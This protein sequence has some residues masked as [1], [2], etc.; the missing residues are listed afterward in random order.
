MDNANKARILM[1]ILS[2]NHNVE[3]VMNDTF[4]INHEMY[5]YSKNTQDN[6]KN[7]N[8]I[9]VTG[10]IVVHTTQPTTKKWTDLVSKE[11]DT[12]EHTEIFNAKHI[13]HN[14][15]GEWYSRKP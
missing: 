9:I 15:V 8:G 7:P 5:Q 3:L 4:L 2:R 14:A 11:H 13:G 10:Y 12:A 6:R 1:P